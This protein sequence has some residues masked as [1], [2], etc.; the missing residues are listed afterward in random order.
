[1]NI[2]WDYTCKKA[3]LHC[4]TT[5]GDGVFDVP[6]KACRIAK[7]NGLDILAV[8]EHGQHLHIENDNEKD[9]WINT[10]IQ[11]HNIN[12]E[13]SDFYAIR[14]FEWTA[15]SIGEYGYGHINILG[16][17]DFCRFWNNGEANST[18]KITNEDEENAPMSSSPADNTLLDD[19]EL[20][21]NISLHPTGIQ[22]TEHI[23]NY[24]MRSPEL[25]AYSNLNLSETASQLVN[26]IIAYIKTKRDIDFPDFLQIVR[27]LV[28]RRYD[29]RH[30]NGN[31]NTTI[32]RLDD[33]YRWVIT[34]RNYYSFDG[35]P[36]VC[37][38]NHPSSF[39]KSNHFKEYE[40][41]GGFSEKDIS[42]L[43]EAFAL[44]ELSSHGDIHCFFD[45]DRGLRF[46]ISTGIGDGE[47]RADSNEYDYRLALS[48]GWKLA[49]ALNEDNHLGDYGTGKDMTGLWLSNNSELGKKAKVMEALRARRT[50]VSENDKTLELKYAWK[51]DGK[52][53]KMGETVKRNLNKDKV[54]IYV[55]AKSKYQ[56]GK[57]KLVR[58]YP[59]KRDFPNYIPSDIKETELG[60]IN[61]TG[62]T[63]SK[64]CPFS[65]DR[66]PKAVYLKIERPD[67]PEK[68]ALSAPV[69]F[70]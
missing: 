52:I 24:I 5:F 31:C 35:K 12:K 34:G 14:G 2:S 53:F 22:L 40:F 1:M 61:S 50:F 58:V 13:P 51:I 60:V 11:L 30:G 66:L 65:L 29:A 69:F 36:I 39:D 27:Y 49:P 54:S 43:K 59:N 45:A 67:F 41:P 55:E 57:I 38:F 62:D 10:K 21:K 37:Q 56:I 47:T 17:R 48:K 42:R 44:C 70:D 19:L 68:Y 4:H 46:G 15:D 8:T 28:Q 23:S 9:E 16:S 20:E 26:K 7:K 63:I 18:M 33:F 3:N 32:L 64:E 6:G 25:A